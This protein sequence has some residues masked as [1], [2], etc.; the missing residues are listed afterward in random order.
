MEEINQEL[1]DVLMNK[2]IENQGLKIVS[3][4]TKDMWL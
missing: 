3:N 2:C 1:F 4:Q